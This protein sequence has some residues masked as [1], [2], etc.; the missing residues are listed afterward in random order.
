M[1]PQV[2]SHQEVNMTSPFLEFLGFFCSN[3]NNNTDDVIII[4]EIFIIVILLEY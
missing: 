2:P 3:D 4:I 1:A